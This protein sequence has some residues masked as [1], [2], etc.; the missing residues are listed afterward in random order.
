M[1]YTNLGMESFNLKFAYKLLVL[2]RAQGPT[3]GNMCG[4]SSKA[5]PRRKGT[6]ECTLSDD[7]FTDE[8]PQIV[9]EATATQAVQWQSRSFNQEPNL[10]I[11]HFL[12][13]AS[14]FPPPT[15]SSCQA[16]G[17]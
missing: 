7:A 12:L 6:P 4:P 16:P 10:Q 11:L 17:R 13:G 2:H 14:F 3:V 5:Y 8:S 9:D 15:A 1:N